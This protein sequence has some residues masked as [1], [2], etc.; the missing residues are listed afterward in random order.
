[1]DLRQVRYFVAV[2]EERNFTRAAERL[3]VAQPPVTRQVQ[4]L[5]EMLGVVLIERGSRPVKLTEAGEFFLAHARLLLDQARDLQAMTQRVGKRERKLSVGFVASTLYGELPDIVRR[6]RE[7]FPLVD[8]TL[9]EMT[10]V[11]QLQALKEGRIDVGFGRLKSE[12]PSIRRI[13]LREERMVVALP[14]EHRL[15]LREGGLRLMEL[16]HDTLLVYPKSPRP[17]FA[18]QVLSVFGEAN[19]TPAQ[20]TEVRELQISM[21]LVAAGQGISIV[22]ESVQAMHHRNVVYRGLEDKHAFSPILFSVRHMD[23]APE[24]S[25]LLAVVYSI[26]DELGFAYQAERL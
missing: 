12:D 16:A 26:Y 2:A 1:M 18:D 20:V 25:D 22:P 5:E 4:Q 6:Y 21:G 24:L 19:V 14:P 11:E 8:V 10:T 7:R 23:R 9:H 13:L 17:S 15:A 3:H